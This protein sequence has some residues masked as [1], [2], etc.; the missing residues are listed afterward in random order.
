MS[1]TVARRRRVPVSMRALVVALFVVGVAVVGGHTGRV[2]A[3]GSDARPFDVWKEKRVVHYDFTFCT[4]SGGT[5]TYIDIYTYTH[6]YDTMTLF[7]IE[8]CRYK[9]VNIRAIRHPSVRPCR[10]SASAR[11]HVPL[12]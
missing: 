2:T 1:V 4:Q 10:G 7:A 5:F 6:V 3:Q 9:H 8:D 12:R 11:G